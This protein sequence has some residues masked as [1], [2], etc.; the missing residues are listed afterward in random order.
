[1]RATWDTIL[2]VI[3]PEHC[4]ACNKEGN[5]LCAICERTII[6]KPVALS[7]STAALFDY[8][9]PLVKK[10][11][12]ALKYDRRLAL[13]RFFGVALYREFF[14][15]LA[16]QPIKSRETMLLIPVP[17][18]KGTLR[19]RGSNHAEVVAAAIA[20]EAVRD[21][22]SFVTDSAILI[23]EKDTPRQ[24]EASSREARLTNLR[25]AFVV[26]NGER[27]NGKTIILIDDVITTGATLREARSALRPFH[28]KRILAIAIAH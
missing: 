19:E 11:I 10:A 25:G 21:G 13:G 18:S 15:H 16:H 6:T 26:E 5:A 14:K 3:F 9:H 1:M 12:W 27:I 2:S 7:S 28:P 20:E 24:V 4:I 17:S 8:G 22:V 23:K